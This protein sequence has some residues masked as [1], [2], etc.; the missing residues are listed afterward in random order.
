[1]FIHLISLFH[2]GEGATNQEL[3]TLQQKM[4]DCV[5]KG[6]QA[7]PQ[8]VVSTVPVYMGATGGMRLVK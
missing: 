2:I 8:Q 7:V 1:M 5:E 3:H 4:V 6:E